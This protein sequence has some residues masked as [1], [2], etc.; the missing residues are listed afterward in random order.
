MRLF[1]SWLFF[2]AHLALATDPAPAVKFI[3]N[4]N[5][6]PAPIQFSARVHGVTMQ[7]EPGRFVY[8]MLDEEKI[9]HIH[10]RSHHPHQIN[11]ADLT[12][13]TITGHAVHVNFAGANSKAT[14]LTFGR[15]SE[16][17]NYFL[18]SDSCQWAA[19]AHAYE[20]FIYP[21]FY[22]GVDMKVYSSGEHVK[23][24][25]I[26]APQGDPMQIAIE[27]SGADVKLTQG[28]L[29]VVTPLGSIIEKKPVAWQWI[30]GN[31]RI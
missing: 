4:K 13:N 20:G 5:Q 31:M 19:R 22:A 27:Y 10:E 21:S 25:F 3:E 18:G 12:D 8:Y 2:S 23:Y 30:N 9:Q 15:S 26:V 24:D 29:T 6:W 7:V 16:Y 28:D 1:L 14:P 17:Y 11:E